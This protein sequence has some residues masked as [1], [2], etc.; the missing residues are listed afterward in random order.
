[1]MIGTVRADATMVYACLLR[2]RRDGVRVSAERLRQA[3]KNLT[4]WEK[5]RAHALVGVPVGAT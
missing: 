3:A 1:M 2:A 5:A 4:S